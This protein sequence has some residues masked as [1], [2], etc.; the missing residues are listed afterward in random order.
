MKIATYIDHTLLKADASKAD[1]IK[2]CSE[3]LEN[4]FYAVP[5]IYSKAPP[6]GQ[7]YFRSEFETVKIANNL[8]YVFV[9]KMICTV[10]NIP[11]TLAFSG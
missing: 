7:N 2:L 4:D 5:Q 6:S 8:N 3:A 10:Y 11:H 9:A 1:I